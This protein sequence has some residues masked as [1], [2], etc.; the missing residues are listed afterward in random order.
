MVGRR[1]TGNETYTLGLLKGMQD[2][3]F[4]LDTYSLQPLP[5]RLHRQ[6]HVAPANPAV[7]IPLTTPLL[8]VRDRLDLF[9]ATYVLPPLMPCPTVVTVHDISYQLHPEWFVPRVRRMLSM[10]VPRSLRS[11]SKIIAI[12]EQ[13]KR[14]IVERYGISPD[15]I[16][17]TYLA[18][19][20]AFALAEAER[21]R[22]PFFLAVG[23]I[24]PR[25]NVG[26]LIRALATVRRRHPEARLVIA[27]KPGLGAQAIHELAA[28]LGVSEAVRFLGYIDDAALR[29]LYATCAAHVHAAWYEGF[30]LTV[31]EAM[32]QGSPVIA[33]GASSIPEVTGDAALLVDPADPQAWAAAMERV[34]EDPKLRD[35]L[36]AGGRERAAM[37]SW[38]RC[39]RQ[40]ADIYGEAL[41]DHGTKG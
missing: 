23:N 11:A 20:P 3:G 31:L 7:R 32:V 39:A 21:E 26:T 17:V 40:T 16:A 5:F 33:S 29:R 2:I 28:S 12:S 22:E 30:G 34:L 37:F 10:L 41:Q 8:A 4:P 25:K 1:E 9:H 35:S 6:H 24:E 27:G 15:K 14:D 36:S 38:E 13:T 19:R 18:P